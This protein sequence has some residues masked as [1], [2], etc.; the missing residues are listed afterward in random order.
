MVR[1]E[2]ET[3]GHDNSRNESVNDSVNEEGALNSSHDPYYAPIIT[4]PEVEV[5]TGEDD[6]EEIFSLRSKLFRFES[7]TTPPEWKER[8]TGKPKLLRGSLLRTTVLKYISL[9]WE[10]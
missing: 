4:L 5:P 8:G 1:L 2:E 10:F 3:N 9:K 6:E 7:T